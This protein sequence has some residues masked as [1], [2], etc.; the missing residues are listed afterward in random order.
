MYYGG[1][2]TSSSYGRRNYTSDLSLSSLTSLNPS[3]QRVKN[4]D[5]GR[6]DRSLSPS[7]DYSSVSHGNAFRAVSTALS[8]NASPTV[9]RR[10]ASLDRSSPATILTDDINFSIKPRSYYDFPSTS[11]AIFSSYTSPIKIPKRTDYTDYLRP[12]LT[13]RPALKLN[14]IPRSRAERQS[15]SSKIIR[16]RKLIKFRETSEEVMEKIRRRIS[17]DI[18][19][20][21]S[22]PLIDAMKQ[23]TE[24]PSDDKSVSE[25]ISS[26]RNSKDNAS[27]T[28]TSGSPGP[29]SRRSSCDQSF[30]RPIKPPPRKNSRTN[31]L[32]ASAIEIIQEQFESVSEDDPAKA[33][34]PPPRKKSIGSTHKLRQSR[35]SSVDILLSEEKT[36]NYSKI[37]ENIRRGRK[38]SLKKLADQ[39]ATEN[40]QSSQADESKVVAPASTPDVTNETEEL[41]LERSRRR[42]RKISIPEPGITE[43][44]PTETRRRRRSRFTSQDSNESRSPSTDNKCS[45]NDKVGNEV[46]HGANTMHRKSVKYKPDGLPPRRLSKS[47]DMV[48]DL[49]VNSLQKISPTNP[50]KQTKSISQV[51]KDPKISDLNKIEKSQSSDKLSSDR[52]PEIENNQKKINLAQITAKPQLPQKESHLACASTV[53]EDEKRLEKNKVDVFQ[54]RTTEANK[55]CKSE[56][57]NSI[58]STTSLRTLETE[59]VQKPL[60]QKAS[61]NENEFLNANSLD[62][63]V[64]KTTAVKNDGFPNKYVD[65]VITDVKDSMYKCPTKVETVVSEETRTNKI[66]EAELKKTFPKNKI[67]KTENK[68]TDK[69]ISV[70]ENIDSDI[71]NDSKILLTGTVQKREGEMNCTTEKF[72]KPE[73]KISVAKSESSGKVKLED[74]RNF[75]EKLTKTENKRQEQNQSSKIHIN[76]KACSSK[77]SPQACKTS[78]IRKQQSNGQASLISNLKP[79]SSFSKELEEIVI[80]C[81]LPKKNDVEQSIPRDQN[82]VVSIKNTALK[83]ELGTG[84][85]LKSEKTVTSNNTSIIPFSKNLD[86]NL[87]N[88]VSQK[89]SENLEAPDVNV[90]HT[91][92]LKPKIQTKKTGKDSAHLKSIPDVVKSTVNFGSK[93]TCDV[94]D[95][96][97]STF[98]KSDDQTET[99]SLLFTGVAKV[100]VEKCDQQSASDSK[101]DKLASTLQNDSKL[102]DVSRLKQVHN[103]NVCA[104]KEGKNM[105]DVLNIEKSRSAVLD[106]SEEKSKAANIEKACSGA[107]LNEKKETQGDSPVLKPD[108]MEMT[109]SKETKNKDVLNVEKSR[110]AALDI[111][112]EKLKPANIKKTNADDIENETKIQSETP[113]IKPDLIPITAKTDNV[114]DKLPS[115]QLKGIASDKQFAKTKGIAEKS[116]VSK[117]ETTQNLDLK[118]AVGKTSDSKENL[119]PTDTQNKIILPEIPKQNIKGFGHLMQKDSK[120]IESV[121]TEARQ[122]K[123]YAYKKC[124]T[125]PNVDVLLEKSNNSTPKSILEST[126]SALKSNKPVSSSSEGNV[127]ATLLG[128]KTSPENPAIVTVNKRESTDSL[129]TNIYSGKKC[130]LKKEPTN[131]NVNLKY[132]S[133]EVKVLE[134]SETKTELTA[135]NNS[136]VGHKALESNKLFSEKPVNE[137][138]AKQGNTTAYIK[139]EK[140]KTETMQKLDSKI[141]GE[142]KAVK[143]KPMLNGSKPKLA[144]LASKN[145]EKEGK[146]QNAERSE[147]M[148]V[149]ANKQAAVEN[150]T[151]IITSVAPKSDKTVPNETLKLPPVKDATKRPADLKQQDSGPNLQTQVTKLDAPK[152]TRIGSVMRKDKS[153]VFSTLEECN[154]DSEKKESSIV[155]RNSINKVTSEGKRPEEQS[156][157][158]AISKGKEGLGRDTK[159]EPNDSSLQKQP[160]TITTKEPEKSKPCKIKKQKLPPVPPPFQ[161]FGLFIKPKEPPKTI[162]ES[163]SSDEESESETETET[164]STEEETPVIKKNSSITNG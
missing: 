74:T 82:V 11:S 163:S 80:V 127:P 142:S 104:Q 135:K 140:N 117:I 155:D 93:E 90:S 34:R 50:R 23:K 36:Q 66:L 141:D 78:E 38:E 15:V 84:G 29:S 157:T 8:G 132:K 61:K 35:K 13:S 12:V 164:E 116:G 85:C 153:Q 27:D 89:K 46:P 91:V 52:K 103:N 56:M 158:T 88:C 49:S 133:S 18:P 57:K 24:D 55:L 145:T 106:K 31:S 22:S 110:S 53:K 125:A 47:T 118:S 87:G 14:Y 123:G 4:T 102:R 147:E 20:E 112:E 10:D 65:P 159:S 149:S 39:A 28:P 150:K 19:E 95:V 77:I 3:I 21:I 43:S 67:S 113:I 51:K 81:K 122:K 86:S 7:R 33:P 161:R 143:A 99:K 2:R 154:G 60:S 138:N 16:E 151:P 107:K 6:S 97:K 131:T 111:K 119:M 114:Q 37:A 126:E 32:I 162:L 62:V 79:N 152:V 63:S 101:Q 139:S 40:Q 48:P 68:Y 72:P 134:N 5:Y 136:T 26:R 25:K 148:S 76:E 105:K 124:T 70:K 58:L 96:V 129:T 71:K 69:N 130:D 109:A 128:K 120:N 17:W 30:D 45:I 44:K 115:N 108:L 156:V 54:N 94:S 92:V 75:N 73:S 83:S 1:N 98:S 160:Q 64:S 121:D 100:S 146:C 41:V 137:E 9:R 59:T 42:R 144:D